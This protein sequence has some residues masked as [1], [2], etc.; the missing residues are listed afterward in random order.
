MKKFVLLF[1]VMLSAMPHTFAQ[2]FSCTAGSPVRVQFTGCASTPTWADNGTTATTL[3]TI[4]SAGTYTVNCGGTLHSFRI[5]NVNACPSFT[6]DL[7]LNASVNPVTAGQSSVLS[8]SGCG[9]GTVSWDRGLVL[10][11]TKRFLLR[12]QLP[13]MQP[14]HLPT[15]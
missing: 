15:G 8:Y 5:T 14:A 13:T 9:G 10:V 6:C 7:S 4:S 11:T 3:R 1:W 12:P 2:N